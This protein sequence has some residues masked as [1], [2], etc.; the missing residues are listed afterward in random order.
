LKKAIR[1]IPSIKDTDT[2]IQSIRSISHNFKKKGSVVL[3][4]MAPFDEDKF[5]KKSI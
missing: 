3:T 1:D 2:E 4:E 5:S